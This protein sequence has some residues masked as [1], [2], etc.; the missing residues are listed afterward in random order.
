MY[1]CA[2]NF[3]ENACMTFMAV[4]SLEIF[5]YYF[6]TVDVPK[7]RRTEL[8]YFFHFNETPSFTSVLTFHFLWK[9]GKVNRKRIF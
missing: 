1:M 2:D 9:D 7:V 4:C 6:G 8:Y 3:L 5:C